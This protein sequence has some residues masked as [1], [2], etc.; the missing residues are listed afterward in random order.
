MHRRT[1]ADLLP[2]DTKLEKTIRNFKKE[3]AAAEAFSMAE[4]EDAKI[5]EWKRVAR[6]RRTRMR[7]QL[8]KQIRIQ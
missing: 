5:E 8:R 3:R 7:L 6:K 2:L 1:G 4:Q